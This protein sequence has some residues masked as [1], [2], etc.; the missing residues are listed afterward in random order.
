MAF[1][2]QV[3][4]L[5]S[6][7]Q[8]PKVLAHSLHLCFQWINNQFSQ[9]LFW[10]WMKLLLSCCLFHTYGVLMHQI[11]I[12]LC[13]AVMPWWAF[14]VFL[15]LYCNVIGTSI[16]MGRVFLYIFCICSKVSFHFSSKSLGLQIIKPTKTVLC[17]FKC[18]ALTV[19]LEFD[20]CMNSWKPFMFFPKDSITLWCTLQL[21][22]KLCFISSKDPVFSNTAKPLD[23]LR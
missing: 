21:L 11:L 12:Y 9:V 2:H 8:L 20:R 23:T 1:W 4:H 6:L 18:S 19:L 16:P 22:W 10:S 5:Y 13:I 17:L 3:H 7:L 15:D 14:G